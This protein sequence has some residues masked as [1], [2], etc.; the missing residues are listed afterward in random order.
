MKMGTPTS[1][2]RRAR[3]IRTPALP[4]QGRRRARD[5]HSAVEPASSSTG[6]R[7][8][9]ICWPM[10]A[11]I[12]RVHL[13][14]GKQHG[15]RR[16]DFMLALITDDLIRIP[17]LIAAWPPTLAITA[18]R[19]PKCATDRSPNSRGFSADCRSVRGSYPANGS[20]E[21][22]ATFH[23]LRTRSARRARRYHMCRR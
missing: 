9:A 19:Q 6:V 16:R 23:G 1:T 3:T 15:R 21:H 14:L 2:A 10:I 8:V 4:I 7:P 22:P 13:W 17:K 11:R 20:F 5:R 12:Y 18:T